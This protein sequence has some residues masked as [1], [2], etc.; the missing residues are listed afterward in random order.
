MINLLR[1]VICRLSKPRCL[2]LVLLG[3]SVYFVGGFFFWWELPDGMNMDWLPFTSDRRSSYMNSDGTTA[4]SK[5]NGGKNGQDTSPSSRP[6]PLNCDKPVLTYQPNQRFCEYNT[7]RIQD[8]YDAFAPYLNGMSSWV[9]LGDANNM[10]QLASA[11]SKRWPYETTNSTSN[12]HACQNLDYYRLPP[13][14]D[15]W[16]PPK[17]SHAEG[18]IGYGLDHPYCM[19]CR[20]CWNVKIQSPQGPTQQER[21]IEYLV[22]EYSRDV[23]IPTRV[24]TTTQETAIYYLEQMKPSVCVASAGLNDPFIIAD[25]TLEQYVTN[26]DHYLDGLHR[27]CEYVVWIGIPGVVE[28]DNYPHKNCELH[29]W[30]NGVFS[31]VDLRKYDNVLVLDVWEETMNTDHYNPLTMTDEYHILLSRLLIS[32]MT[33]LKIH[34][35]NLRRLGEDDRATKS[36]MVDRLFF[37]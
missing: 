10:Q 30:N 33:G 21:Y 18:P 37:E 20:Q 34:R 11:V 27:A 31:L 28:D 8:C 7:T 16:V 1:Q 13:P 12:R 9:F 26:V 6:L 32:F 17:H 23:S 4:G 35:N 15:G 24:S 29:E 19:D 3:A 22:V 25:M 36:E 14:Y 5:F 2:L